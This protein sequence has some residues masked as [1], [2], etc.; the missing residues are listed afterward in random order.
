MK[1]KFTIS[2]MV[3]II[4]GL[5][6]V[7]CDKFIE[8][9][10]PESQLTGPA[11]YEDQTTA[12]A[13]LSDLY[14]RLRNGGVLTGNTDGTSMVLGLYAD[15]LKYYGTGTSALESFY[16]NSVIPS[17]TYIADLWSNSYAQIYAANALLE[18]LENSP[19]IPESATHQLQGETLF[20]RAILHF[21]LVNL[22]GDIPYITTTDYQNNAQAKRLPSSEVMANI[23]SDLEE[24]DLKL[25]Y[26]YPA[27]NRVRANKAVV[28]A[29]LARVHLYLEHW[30]LAEMYAADV[31]GQTALYAV[32][33]NLDAV[34][35]KGSTATIWQLHPGVSGANTLQGKIFSFSSG[36][37]AIAS[38]N[39]EL[40][41]SFTENDL[42]RQHWIKSVTDGSQVW[43]HP[44]KYKLT[45]NTGVSEEYSIVLRLEEQLLIRAEARANIGDIDGAK[46]DLNT[47]RNRAGLEDSTAETTT[48]LL[49][50]I[51]QERKLELFTEFGH[52]WLD[53]KRKGMAEAALSPIKPA[54]GP[55]NLLF[56]LPESELLL[57]PNLEPQNTGY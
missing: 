3:T 9:D 51:Q 15:E 50:D 25:T 39:Q 20:I 38:L 46:Q 44:Y 1:T 48:E 43:Y 57:N 54:W 41:S 52:R 33:S 35:L 45:E 31:I 17:N 42:R 11:V 29:L 21:Y 36:P 14:A 6:L 37:P 10:L 7:G 19:E 40:V 27:Q 47:I 53:L 28:R 12:T 34:F 32:E 4:L 13:A 22:F 56:P 30:S 23:I 55:K 5:L 26:E 18:G 2:F 49:A 24:A 8:V 16:S